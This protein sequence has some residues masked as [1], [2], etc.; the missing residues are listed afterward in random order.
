MANATTPRFWAFEISYDPDTEFYTL[1][2]TTR[3]QVA[4][5]NQDFTEY[6]TGLLLADLAGQ[7][8]QVISD[9]SDLL[10]AAGYTVTGTYPT[11]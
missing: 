5:G 8:D 1:T 11:A 6:Q 2:T 10:T 7:V 9:H 3:T 4:G